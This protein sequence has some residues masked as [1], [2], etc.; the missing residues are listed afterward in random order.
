M[1]D[2]VGQ[3][4]GNYRIEKLLGS[5]GFADVYLGKHVHLDSKTAVKVIR[6]QLSNEDR[7]LFRNE[8]RNLV[9]LI[10]PNIVRLLDFGLEGNIPYFVMDYAPYGSLSDKHPQGT[11]LPLSTVILYVKQIAEALQYAHDQKLIHRDVK[12]E[13]MLIGHNNEILLSD[14]GIAVVAHSTK[15]MRTEKA[16]GT[17]SYMAPEQLQKKPRPA[18][19]QYALG[20]IVYSWLTGA[21][22]F[23]GTQL[24]VAMQ[25]LT[26][27]APSLRSIVPS[28]SVAVDRVVLKA[29]TKDPQQR[30]ETIR[31]FAQALEEAEQKHISKIPRTNIIK[32]P[33]KRLLTKPVTNSAHPPPPYEKIPASLRTK[34]QWLQEG[35][36][37][38]NIGLFKEAIVVYNNAIELDPQNVHAYRSRGYAYERLKKYDKALEDYNQ[39]IK[40]DPFHALTYNNR[41]FIY[42]RYKDYRRAIEDY[43]KALSIDPMCSYARNNREDAYRSLME[44]PKRY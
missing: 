17:A 2:F 12:P 29:L 43:D 34:E 39:A 7:E 28:L 44:Q 22:P 21:L 19:D 40:L 36:T 1:G 5:G 8:A 41:G 33:E 31:A 9:R 13:N 23:N 18:S 6:D 42:H 24:E 11:R 15:S 27:P 3:Q 14:F 4:L 37:L 30:Y 35:I 38:S 20:V 25:H 26:E 10:H 32:E 16:I